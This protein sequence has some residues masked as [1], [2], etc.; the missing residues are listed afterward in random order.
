MPFL[1]LRA[2]ISA[3]FP[4]V[5]CPF[6]SFRPRILHTPPSDPEEPDEMRGKGND[7]A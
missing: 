7:S 6:V 4:C 1:R 3:N 5:S 2:N